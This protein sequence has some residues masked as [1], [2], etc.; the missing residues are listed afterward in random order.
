MADRCAR[1]CR[2][3]RRA[4]GVGEQVEHIDGTARAA[5]H[6][7]DEIPVGR[8]LGEQAGVLEAHGLELEGQLAVMD[9]PLLGQT[10]DL[11]FAA[12]RVRAVVDGVRPVPCAAALGA[13][14]DGLRVRAHQHLI[15]PAL[16]FLAAAAVK[17]GIVLPVVRDPHKTHS[18]FR[19]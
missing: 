1:V 19:C 3:E 17:H 4:A 11:P 6:A 2:S 8:L 14:P 12:A 15:A 16:D 13:R 9:R 7:V 10:A 18:P 5:D